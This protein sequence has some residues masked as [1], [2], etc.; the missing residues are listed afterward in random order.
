MQGV[1]LGSR[2]SANTT[3]NTNCFLKIVRSVERFAETKNMVYDSSAAS[4]AYGAHYSQSTNF[5]NLPRLLDSLTQANIAYQLIKQR[6]YI[7]RQA[8]EQCQ[9]IVELRLRPEGYKKFQQVF[10]GQRCTPIEAPTENLFWDS[11][12]GLTIHISLLPTTSAA[13]RIGTTRLNQSSV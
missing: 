2:R 7:P 11:R 12:T 10:V 8:T 4:A 5:G 13:P 9:T 1:R 6:P 3:A